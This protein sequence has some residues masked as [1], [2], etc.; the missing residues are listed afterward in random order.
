MCSGAPLLERGRAHFTAEEKESRDVRE[1]VLGL[2]L[3]LGPAYPA[4]AGAPLSDRAVPGGP[5]HLSLALTLRPSPARV[6]APR[7]PLSRGARVA[8]F[9]RH[10]LPGSATRGQQRPGRK[11]PPRPAHRRP[12]GP[13]ARPEGRACPAQ[14]RVRGCLASSRRSA[15]SP[16][17]LVHP[18][19]KLCCPSLVPS[20]PEP[21][22]WDSVEVEWGSQRTPTWQCGFLLAESTAVPRSGLNAPQ[23]CG[24]G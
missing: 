6:Q 15:A 13:P 9:L 8:S 4:T 1:L 2:P 10:P 14:P 19:W 3:L 5:R 24:P 18:V 23:H 22:G 17:A 12:R 21:G 7:G 20:Q 16:S 11:R